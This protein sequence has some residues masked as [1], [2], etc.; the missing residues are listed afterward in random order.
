MA[1]SLHRLWNIGNPFNQ[2]AIVYAYQHDFF[3]AALYYYRA[4]CVRKP[5]PTA[6]DNLVRTLGKCLE[7]DRELW[8]VRRAEEGNDGP[9]EGMG[10]AED[11]GKGKAKAQSNGKSGVDND[12]SRDLES[13]FKQDVVL[14]HALWIGKCR[15]AWSPNS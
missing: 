12:G 2:L 7:V 3:G 14:L 9:N 13:K 15:Y 8:R 11:T 4:L 1:I 10:A 5:F 6:Q